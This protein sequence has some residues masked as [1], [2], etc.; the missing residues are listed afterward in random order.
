MAELNTSSALGNRKAAVVSELPVGVIALP[1]MALLLAVICV[2][3]GC[4]IEV[5][6]LLEVDDIIG[7]LLWAIIEFVNIDIILVIVDTKGSVETV[8]EEIIGFIDRLLGIRDAVNCVGFA[9]LFRNGDV[10]S[11]RTE[12]AMDERMLRCT[13]LFAID[14]TL[15]TGI[16]VAKATVPASVMA[17]DGNNAESIRMR[18]NELAVIHFSL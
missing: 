8:E 6:I 1:I 12:L 14:M 17:D 3:V 18:G 5:A 11:F 4:V 16:P 7:L 2:A 13:G 15:A 10:I 9:T